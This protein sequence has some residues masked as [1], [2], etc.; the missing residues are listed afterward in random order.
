MSPVLMP[1][2]D[3]TRRYTERLH[4]Y[5]E[6][7]GPAG[8]LNPAWDE[9]FPRVRDAGTETRRAWEQAIRRD[10]RDNG[11]TFS[12]TP[13][14]L[15]AK[16]KED[17]DP[18]PWVFSSKEWSGLEAG[19]AQ[20][21]RL[22]DSVARDL[23]GPRNLIRDG[24]LPADLLYAHAGYLRACAN[25]PSN[26]GAHL[27]FYA[28]DLARGPDGR[29]W[30]LDD[31]TQAPSGAG[32][33]LENRTIL[34][35]LFPDM[36]GTRHVRRLA[37]FFRRFR[38]SMIRMHEGRRLDPRV[39]V[40]TPGPYSA[41]YFE[42][43]FLATYLGYTLAQGDDL[44]M[45]DGTL[46]LKTL[47]GLQSVDI[48]LR[49]VD[50]EYCDPLELRRDSFLGIPGLLGAMRN[51]RAACVNHPGAG[52]LENRGLMPFFPGMC[53]H[54][55]GE[56]PLLPSAATWWCGQPREMNLVLERAQELVIKPIHRNAG[57]S[58][59]Y[60]WLCTKAELDAVR[61]RIRAHPMGY[62]GQERIGF[63][64]VPLLLEGRLEPRRSVLR[65]FASA[66]PEGY[67]VMPG[68]LARSAADPDS[69]R[70]SVGEGGILKDVWV[71]AE[72]AE[73]HQSLWLEPH[74]NGESAWFGGVFT[75]RA[76]DHLFWTGRYAERIA[77]QVRL[78]RGMLQTRVTPAEDE[79]TTQAVLGR[80]ADLMDLH[81][82]LEP[83]PGELT[84]ESRLARATR[85]DEDLPVGALRHNLRS[86]LYSAYSVRDVW[87][88]DSW[89]VLTGIETTGERCCADVDSPFSLGNDFDELIEKLYAFYGLNSGGMTRESGWAMLMLGRTLE[90]GLGLCELVQGLLLCGEENPATQTSLM[91]TT[92]S[93]NEN[94]ITYRRHY[95]TTPSI[96]PVL[97]LM[98]GTETNPRALI[99]H[100]SG[101]MDLLHT[102]P[103]PP[104]APDTTADLQLSLRQMK[105]R[106]LQRPWHNTQELDKVPSLLLEARAVLKQG[107][108][109]VSSAYFSHTAHL[110][111]EN[112]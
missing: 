29:M 46:W 54:L 73:P 112:Y 33:A 74:P 47:E 87:S 30:V 79:T 45:R 49:R 6:A 27:F 80:M 28:A 44:V 26:L 107:S 75:S 65:V 72:E 52:V 35:R 41:T 92:L 61:E 39:V 104:A 86:L 23:L 81:C 88:Q 71:L 70:V 98:L 2:S 10:L 16:R 63:S 64:S 8:D 17:L 84:L 56:E 60:G 25:V 93:L 19:I 106:L 32:Y 50:A 97:D 91:D 58:S 40:L 102:L 3:E 37:S 13:D 95:R 57:E 89:R 34:S 85:G 53:R 21:A 69:H 109:V 67:D 76:A 9:V 48:L 111:M 4:G 36:L 68:G 11:L 43:A 38:E 82:G 42:H 14:P 108:E 99:A 94:L 100:L 1:I 66:S 62:V 83:E 12:M 103:P 7:V 15:R 96:G 22:L 20:R 51:G 101:C 59:V 78:A 18:V 77:R 110:A 90:A 24:L 55:L 105:S 31:K 5:D